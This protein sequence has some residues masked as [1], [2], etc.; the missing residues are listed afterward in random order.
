[1]NGSV[2][3]F[4]LNKR[5]NNL[6]LKYLKNKALLSN[7][8]AISA[9]KI[10]IDRKIRNIVH[11]FQQKCA[12][13]PP[14]KYRGSVLDGRDITTIQVKDAMFKFFITAFPVLSWSSEGSKDKNLSK[15]ILIES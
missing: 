9:S 1:M 5:I 13:T 3:V 6:K 8:V 11:E 15:C 4:G 2:I 12:Y 10:A 14:T 7:E